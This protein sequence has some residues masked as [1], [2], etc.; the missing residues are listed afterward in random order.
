MT[1]KA[2]VQ[3]GIRLTPAQMKARRQ[4]NMAIGWSVGLLAIL[5]WAVTIVRLGSTVMQR[6]M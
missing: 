3:D 5:F 2:P 1:D 4:R 6:P